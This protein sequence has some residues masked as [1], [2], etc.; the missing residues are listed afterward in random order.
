MIA[1]FAND[2]HIMAPMHGVPYFMLKMGMKSE[3]K[4]MC[5]DKFFNDRWRDA[6]ALYYATMV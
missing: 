2:V 3:M 6:S 5:T 4:K 1:N